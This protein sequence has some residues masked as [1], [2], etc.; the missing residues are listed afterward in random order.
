MQWLEQFVDVITII[1]IFQANP[2][3]CP[4]RDNNKMPKESK[5]LFKMNGITTMP[6]F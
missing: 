5:C 3:T 1:S 4:L 6:T 2:A